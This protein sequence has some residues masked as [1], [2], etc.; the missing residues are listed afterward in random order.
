MATVR[1]VSKR[2]T[3]ICHAKITNVLRSV[4]Q[5]TTQRIFNLVIQFNLSA[6]YLS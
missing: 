5:V 4:T 3:E 6:L 2:V 1:H